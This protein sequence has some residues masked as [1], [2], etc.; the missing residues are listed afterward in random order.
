MPLDC[1]ASGANSLDDVRSL[2]IRFGQIE[3]AA[4]DATGEVASATLQM[5][6]DRTDALARL[7][8]AAI[9][10][11]TDRVP[12]QNLRHIASGLREADLPNPTV[13][14]KVPEGFAFYSLFPEQYV[15][16]AERW[17]GEREQGGDRHVLV[18]GI[19]SIGTTLSAVV[20]Q[21]LI[22]RGW[23]ARRLTVRPSGHPFDRRVQLDPGSL[24]GAAHALVVDEGPG[25]SGS[26]MASAAR[27]LVESGLSRERIAFL[28]GHDGEPGAHAS[29]EVRRW[30]SEIPRYSVP[31]DQVR[32]N[33]RSLVDRLGESAQQ[34]LASSSAVDRI[35]DLSAGRWPSI[36]SVPGGARVF[37]LF[38][39]A[40]YRCVLRDGRAML[41]KFDGLISRSPSPTDSPETSRQP[42]GR[43]LGFVGFPWIEGTPLT[44]AD[45][46]PRIIAQ[47]GGYIRKCAGPS[48][49]PHEQES[50]FDRLAEMLYWNT[51]ES[52]GEGVANL[53]RQLSEKARAWV[54]AEPSRGYGDGRLSPWEWIRTPDGRIVK[55]DAEGHDADHT[56]IGKQPMLW[57]AAGAIVEWGMDQ[58]AQD[59]LL[60]SAGLEAIP[61]AWL[62]LHRL[63]YAAFRLGMSS[64]CQVDGSFYREQ[65]ARLV[66]Q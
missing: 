28:P 56:I 46:N 65:L 9:H 12:A 66:R 58:P 49:S 29:D 54:G 34:I 23:H 63:A 48:L 17:A 14:V 53:A 6:R 61:S 62:E 11:G 15:A 51:R 27:A 13:T 32:W 39:R 10:S 5:L 16:A 33:G 31:L 26:S 8:V 38:E 57:D 45:A 37:P 50:G 20:A 64:M 35:E 21:A 52:L 22:A 40:K 44:A 36:L 24:R 3:Q 7:L 18:V 1:S 59:L 41:W 2:L 55:V 47:I 42:I 25:A 43:L 30:W 19:R 60:R 4:E